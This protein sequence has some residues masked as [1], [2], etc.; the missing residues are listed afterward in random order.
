MV[1]EFKRAPD[2]FDHLLVT[3]EKFTKWTKVWPIINLKYE[4]AAEFI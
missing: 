4:Q 2:G 1:R 3:I